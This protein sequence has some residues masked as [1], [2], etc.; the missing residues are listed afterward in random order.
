MGHAYSQWYGN[1][2]NHVHNETNHCTTGDVEPHH[3]GDK[4]KFHIP[5]WRSLSCINMVGHPCGIFKEKMM[6]T[7]HQ[8]GKF[9]SMMRR[10]FYTICHEHK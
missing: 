2:T 7:N 6:A 9:K 4:K 5:D 8:L 10:N 1:E 3:Y